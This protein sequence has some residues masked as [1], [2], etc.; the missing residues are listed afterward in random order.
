MSLELELRVNGK[1]IGTIDVRRQLDDPSRERPLYRANVREIHAS[2][3]EVTGRA[4][5]IEHDPQQGAWEL[6]RA[7]LEE[8]PK[9]AWR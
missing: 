2:G 4:N 1:L 7:V 3:K 9:G 8:H 6:I 5:W